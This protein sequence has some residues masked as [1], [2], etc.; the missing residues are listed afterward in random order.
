MVTAF[1]PTFP[2]RADLALV[3]G[4]P[5]SK[6]LGLRTAA[7][8]VDTVGWWGLL[9]VRNAAGV[10]VAESSTA[11]GRITVGIQGTAPNQ[12]NVLI[13]IPAMVTAAL[14]DWGVGDWQ[15]QLGPASSS[16]IT[17]F[18]GKSWLTPDIAF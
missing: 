17:Y 4:D 12:W 13:E 10:L 16:A 9:Q 11:N 7:G 14:T 3:K 18:G 6:A 15:L 8:L 2:I 5:Y 1:L